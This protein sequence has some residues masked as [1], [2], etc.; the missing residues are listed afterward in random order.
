MSKIFIALF[1]SIFT[2]ACNSNSK[3]NTGNKPLTQNVPSDDKTKKEGTQLSDW[4]NSGSKGL[5]ASIYYMGSL[6]SKASEYNLLERLYSTTWYQS[7]EDFDD[8]R[9]ETEEEF[10]FFNSSSEISKRQYEN[11][12]IDGRDEYATLAW[13]K[14]VST[15]SQGGNKDIN[16][17]IVK[18]TERGEKDVE[19][20]GYYLYDRDTLYIIDG[21]DINEVERKLKDIIDAVDNIPSKYNEDKYVLSTKTLN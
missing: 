3:P 2:F 5:N 21:D 17:V 11:G 14:N 4:N 13:Q 7:E 10:I 19:Y 9:L 12:K 1:L 18:N 8:G 16:G 6:D 15:V 20:E